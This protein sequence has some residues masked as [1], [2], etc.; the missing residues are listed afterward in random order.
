MQKVRLE[1]DEGFLVG[2]ALIPPFI[3][4]PDV[5]LWGDRL[6]INW[7]NHVDCKDKDIIPWQDEKGCWIYREGFGV[8]IVNPVVGKI[9]ELSTEPAP[10]TVPPVT[11][12][13]EAQPDVR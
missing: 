11:P 1:T 13:T 10:P 8:Y 5:L 9:E 4:R 12:G 3:M 2:Y 7:K 6:F